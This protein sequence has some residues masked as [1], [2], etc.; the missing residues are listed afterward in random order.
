MVSSYGGV[1][2]SASRTNYG[3]VVQPYRR[4]HVEVRRVHIQ[5]AK[6]HI[7]DLYQ[8]NDIKKGQKH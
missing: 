6:T 7:F 4:R 2:Y 3:G 5:Y 8:Q 1:I